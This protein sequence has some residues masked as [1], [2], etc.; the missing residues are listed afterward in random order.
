MDIRKF[1]QQTNQTNK[2]NDNPIEKK[3]KLE[4][5][6]WNVYTDGSTFNNGKKGSYGGIGVFFSDNS[7]LNISEAV[8]CKNVTNNICELEACRKGI[9]QIVLNKD[10]NVGDYI[11]VNTDSQYLINCITLWSTAWEKNGW[12]NKSKRPVKNK[13]LIKEIKKLYLKYNV[14]FKHI[15]AHQDFKGEKD[16]NNMNYRDW[17]GNQMADKLAVLGSKKNL[18][19]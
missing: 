4:S 1:F 5:K 11:M 19:L 16:E 10:F 15:L 3:P 14:Q 6:S 2:C 13:E 9:L 8:I 18:L 17:Y 12:I 7:P